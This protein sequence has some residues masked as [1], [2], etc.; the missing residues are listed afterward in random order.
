MLTVKYK[1]NWAN[2]TWI[3]DLNTTVGSIEEKGKSHN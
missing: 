3:I 2:I 1:E